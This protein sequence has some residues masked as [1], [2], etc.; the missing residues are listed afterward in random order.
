E[1]AGEAVAA[2][3]RI[4]ADIGAFLLLAGVVGL[5][6]WGVWQGWKEGR[7]LARLARAIGL[8]ALAMSAG[9]FVM[10]VVVHIA[11]D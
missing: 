11:F 4:G 2:W 3:V 1:N 8:G 7:L 6:G 5:L 9:F 10:L